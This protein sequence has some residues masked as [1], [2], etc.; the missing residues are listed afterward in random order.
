MRNVLSVIEN[1]SV[2]QSLLEIHRDR[3]TPLVTPAETFRGEIWRSFHPD[4]PFPAGSAETFITHKKM[5]ARRARPNYPLRGFIYCCLFIRSMNCERRGV[6]LRLFLFSSG[7]L[8][9]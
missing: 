2:M 4:N 1:I 9:M 8:Q 6:I 3:L 7:G 5:L